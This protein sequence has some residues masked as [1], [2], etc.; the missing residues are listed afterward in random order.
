MGSYWPSLIRH[1][2]DGVVAE[3]ENPNESQTS[4]DNIFRLKATVIEQM[5]GG[6]STMMYLPARIWVFC[7]QIMAH[8]TIYS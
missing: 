3:G 7:I 6:A 2:P 5:T 8:F 1:Q 4:P